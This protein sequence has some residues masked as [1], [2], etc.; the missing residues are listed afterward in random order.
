MEL[1]FKWKISKERANFDICE[2]KN[3][4]KTVKKSRI[5]IYGM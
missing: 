3:N 5:A 1:K 2:L 4:F